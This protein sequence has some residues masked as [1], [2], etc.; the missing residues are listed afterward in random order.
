MPFSL[1]PLQKEDE[2]EC[3]RCGALISYDLTRCLECGVNLFDL[4]DC[5]EEALR[6]TNLEVGVHR[7]FLFTWLGDFFKRLTS[8]PYSTAE[9]FSTV[10]D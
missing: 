4:G 10:L 1:D 5:F 3:A 2:T 9:V 7:Y 8:K 6:Y